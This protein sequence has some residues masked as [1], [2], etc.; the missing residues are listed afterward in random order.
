MECAPSKK[1]ES[2]S[3]DRS[4]PSMFQRKR[5]LVVGSDKIAM[6]I[7]DELVADGRPVHRLESLDRAGSNLR[8]AGTLILADL[9]GNPDELIQQVAA[10]CRSRPVRRPPLRLILVRN[11]EKTGSPFAIPEEACLTLET[12]SAE[13][14]AARAL[15]ARW[16]PHRGMDPLYGQIPHILFAGF[17]DPAPALLLH[18][19]RLIHYGDTQPV[20]SLADEDPEALRE[21][22]M[23]AYPQAGQFCRLRFIYLED[24][25]LGDAPPVTGAFVCLPSPDQGLTTARNLALAIARAQRVTP[26]IH[27]EIGDTI[28]A[29]CPGDWDGQL[30]PFSWLHEACNPKVLLDGRGDELARVIH[31]HY[32]DSIAAQGRDPDAE[33][34]GRSWERLDTSY[35][36]ASR[37]QA[38]HLQAKLAILDCRAVREE[39]VESFTFAPLEA[40]R[41]AVVEHKRWAADR[42][43]DGWTYASE[44]N[45]ARKHHPQ[46]IPYADL[47]EPMKDLDRFAVR[48]APTLLARSGRGLVR[49]LVVAVVEPQEGCRTDRRLERLADQALRRLVGRYPDRSLVLASTLESEASRLVVHRAVDEFEAGLFLLSPRPLPEALSAQPGEQA[50]RHLLALAARAERRICLPGAGEPK[51]WFAR[52]AEIRLILGRGLEAEKPG[53]KVRLDPA[54]GLPDWSFEY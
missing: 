30:V 22:L 34:A 29:G 48:L 49:M 10:L 19:L 8:S 26:L 28:P 54:K 39:L 18:T 50:R 27:L 12:F 47:S 41:L 31:E 42:Y 33:P 38:D 5:I 23:T 52:R 53:K 9:A 46:L 20:I 15:L 4:K 7:C 14:E 13:A 32:S 40:E 21:Q 24:T 51:R 44:R 6:K 3:A 35:R 45:N 1:K 17:A 11:G 16:P 2:F 25:E 36:N 37:H 43:L